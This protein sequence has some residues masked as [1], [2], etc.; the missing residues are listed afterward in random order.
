MIFSLH[1]RVA[2][3]TYSYTQEYYGSKKLETVR[4]LIQAVLRSLQLLKNTVS[5]KEYDRS[6]SDN[7][8]HRGP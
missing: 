3:L 5:V 2:L 6:V 8:S 1:Y 4:T 7:V